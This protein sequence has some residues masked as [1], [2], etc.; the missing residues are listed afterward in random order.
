MNEVFRNDD[1]GCLSSQHLESGLQLVAVRQLVQC[2]T[3]AVEFIG[4]ARMFLLQ[5]GLLRNNV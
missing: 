3:D 1:S 2:E 4:S 5:Q